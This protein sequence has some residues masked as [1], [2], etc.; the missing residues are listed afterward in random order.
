MSRVPI[1][2]TKNIFGIVKYMAKNNEPV[3]E[4]ERATSDDAETIC[5]IRDRAWIEA[6][7][8]PELGITSEQIELN[9]KGRNGEFVPR[10]IAYLKEQFAKDNETGLTTYVAKV[11]GKVVGYVDLCID[12]QARR[13]IGAMYM[14]PEA[15]GKG[16][17]STLMHRA[18]DVLG[19]D[20]DIYLDVISYNQNA[21]DFYK[22][23][24][25]E[26]TDA[27]VPDDDEAPDYMIHLPQIEMVL[28]AVD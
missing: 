2:N 28:R 10:R 6:Y 1:Y 17:G 13:R 12:G 25:F 11:D 14:A 23:F 21:I 16:V 22:H 15:Q 3:V 20:Q 4:I 9:A 24:G 19:R 5:D 18:L 8:N 26:T 27:I 7:P